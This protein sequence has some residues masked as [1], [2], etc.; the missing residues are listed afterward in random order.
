MK[1]QTWLGALLVAQLLLALGLYANSR[2]ESGNLAEPLLDFPVA[3]IDRIEIDDRTNMTTLVKRDDQWLLTSPA[4][5]PASQTRVSSLLATLAGLQTGWPVVNTDSGRERF[6]VT[7]DNYQRQLGLYQGDELL[8]IW[9]FG[10]SPGFR[11]THSRRDGNDEVYALAFNNFDL[12]ADP[13]DWLDKTLLSSGTPES[14]KGPDFE[15]VKM[16]EQWQLAAGAEE[17]DASMLNQEQAGELAQ[18]FSNLRVLRV[19]N[20]LPEGERATFEVSSDTGTW[21]YQFVTADDRHYVKRTDREQAFTIS[22]ADYERIVNLTRDKLLTQDAN[23]AGN[24][25]GDGNA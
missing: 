16:G 23:A 14:I 18:A 10:T 21:E 25:A 12:P 17:N 9:F 24:A 22:Q 5:L 20:G 13:N 19:E 11:K 1:T 6:E 8:D 15:L 2:S 4:E 3:D 7:E